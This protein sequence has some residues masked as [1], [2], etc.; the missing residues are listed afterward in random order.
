[1]EQILG[2]RPPGANG[3]LIKEGDT[4]HFVADVIEASRQV[5]VIVDFWA[6]W[7][8]PCKQLGPLLE[9]AVTAAGGAV[10][11][12]KI[13]VDANPELAQQMRIQSIPA[14]YAFKDGRPVDGFV[15]ALPQSQIKAFVD[16]LLGGAPAGPSPIEE[17]L[18]AAKAA[19]ETGDVGTA[20]ALFGQIL[21]HDSSNV[22]ALA[23]LARCRIAAGD[24]K[25]ARQF[26]SSL[27]ETAGS[28]PDV[29]AARAALELAEAAKKNGASVEAMAKR[30]A[31]DA[32]DHQARFDLAL[33]HF[34]ANNAGSAIDELMEIIRRNRSWNEDAARKQLIKIFEAL[35]SGHELTLSGRRRLSSLLF[36]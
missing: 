24:V 31:L 13:N 21:N 3:E 8:G 30:L 28:D 16:R 11:L 22:K 23:G 18:K 25:Q 19:L 29:A 26:L 4:A 20:A 14:V 5:P 34:A 2:G 12:V 32:N 15:G 9:K 17:A 1:M 27:P 7:C 10:R 36:S 6:P 33:A 35:G